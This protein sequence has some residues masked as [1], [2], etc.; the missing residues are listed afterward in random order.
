MHK[1]GAVVQ[2]LE[3]VSSLRV[4]VPI[5]GLVRVKPSPCIPSP[6]TKGKSLLT[7]GTTGGVPRGCVVF[8]VCIQTTVNC[9]S[10]QG[11]GV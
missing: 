7:K 10:H 6:L 3:M 8:W 11:L 2:G 1:R 5:E 4:R 9:H